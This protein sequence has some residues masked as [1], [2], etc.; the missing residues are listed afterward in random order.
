MCKINKGLPEFGKDSR[1]KDG[2]RYCCKM[3]RKKEYNPEEKSEYNRNWYILNR[4][5]CIVRSTKRA[6]EHKELIK[7]YKNQY[8][9][10][11]A[12]I[13]ISYRLKRSL[14]TRL[15][16][17]IK[18]NQK[19]GSAIKDLGCSVEFL[20]NY[21]ES[22]FQSG[23]NW[24]NYGNKHGNWSIDHKM[25]LSSTENEKEIIK[26]CHYSNLQPMWHIDNLKKGKKIPVKL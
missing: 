5:S 21:L 24:E 23:M 19:K 18:N 1:S 20:R 6:T 11:R 3:C 12:K 8:D 25:P 7:V 14:R 4:E 2:H 22:Q 16:Q 17:A 13:D 26:L 15:R 10:D 9:K